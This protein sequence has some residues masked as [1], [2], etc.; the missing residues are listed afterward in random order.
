MDGLRFSVPL[1]GRSFVEAAFICALWETHFA[2]EFTA[3]A[4]VLLVCGRRSR[5]V[6]RTGDWPPC[7][8]RRGHGVLALVGPAGQ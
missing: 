1:R 2:G 7:S 3:E 6:L 4:V 5:F 8:R